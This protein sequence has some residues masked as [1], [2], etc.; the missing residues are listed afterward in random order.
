MDNWTPLMTRIAIGKGIGFFIGLLGLIVMPYFWPDASWYFRWGILFWYTTFGAIIGVFGVVDYLP[1]L[2]L[3]LPWWIRAPFLGAWLNFVLT[4]F[5]YEP[6]Q[7][8]MLAY[9]GA[10]GLLSSPFWFVAEGALIG[11]IIGFTATRYA[12]EGKKVVQ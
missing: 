6:L 1:I 3:P 5:I 12:G 9:F 11:L 2:K 8:F 4:L 7:Q 10:D